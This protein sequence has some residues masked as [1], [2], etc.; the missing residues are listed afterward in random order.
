MAL[1]IQD[2]DDDFA[3]TS[4]TRPDEEDPSVKAL[5]KT[6]S[7]TKSTNETTSTGTL[8]FFPN[9]QISLTSPSDR[10]VRDIQHAQ[11]E[12]IGS[13]PARPIHTPTGPASSPLRAS[14]RRKTTNS[15]QMGTPETKLG[16]R[17]TVKTYGSSSNLTRGLLNPGSSLFD[18]LKAEEQKSPGAKITPREET[19]PV[20]KSP[21]DSWEIPASLRQDFQEHELVSM[22]PDPSST[23][24][25]NTMTQQRL[26]EQAL[27]NQTLPPPAQQAEEAAASTTSS[28]PWSTYLEK[29]PEVGCFPPVEPETC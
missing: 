27:L 5:S 19:E 6:P 26:V 17:E 18:D 2:S 20:Y 8:N 7:R 24:P 15:S 14:K 9:A 3:V 16:R 22:F 12:L 29:S 1:E 25:D 13:S 23:V 10:L 21:G 4:P 28:F 11:L